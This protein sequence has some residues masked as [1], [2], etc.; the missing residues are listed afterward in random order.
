MI[1][2]IRSPHL[3]VILWS[4]TLLAPT[5]A[6]QSL[7]GALIGT[8]RDGQG[9]LIPGARVRVSSP[10]LLRRELTT[11]TNESGQLRFPA[12]PPGSYSL[13]V[14]LAGF[15]TYREERIG[16]GA[17][18]TIERTVVLRVAGIAES[19]TVEGAGSRLE[20]RGSGLESRLAAEDLNAIPTGRFSPPSDRASTRTSS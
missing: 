11:T 10:A 9:S 15:A 6:A 2:R 12:L 20:A 5:A 7:T 3:A 1:P 17:G 8:V 19:I 13:D 18:A 4:C 16:I 14:E